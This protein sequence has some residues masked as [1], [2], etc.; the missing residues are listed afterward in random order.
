M[1]E[2]KQKNIIIIVD[3]QQGFTMSE[4]TAYLKEK[5]EELLERKIFDVVIA[6]RFLNEDNSVF[7][8]L[9]S[10]KR[11]KS[12]EERTLI[13]KVEE[14]A[15][16]VEDKYLYT[17]VNPN[18]IQRLCQLNGGQYPEKVFLAGVDTDCC[19]LSIA[20]DLFENNIRPIVLIDYCASNGGMESH[21]A[22]IVCMKRLLGA[23]QIKNGE[24]REKGELYGG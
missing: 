4:Q 22:A 7:E 21:K 10:W 6:T 11:L 1:L 5:I 20:I 13:Q 3:M 17:C 15:D 16:C 19:V 8:Q 24:I 14:C 2:K 18:F 12:E 9:H 23:K